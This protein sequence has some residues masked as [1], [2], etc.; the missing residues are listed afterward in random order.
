MNVV[1]PVWKCPI[2]A[3][4]PGDSLLDHSP[5]EHQRIDEYLASIRVLTR[6]IGSLA[7]ELT[8]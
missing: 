5:N 6:A 3:Y 8:A 4:G 2:A 7:R 1:G